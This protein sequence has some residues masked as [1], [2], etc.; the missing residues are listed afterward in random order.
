MFA[1]NQLNERIRDMSEAVRDIREQTG[2]IPAIQEHLGTLNGSVARHEQLIEANRAA[3][4]AAVRE[5]HSAILAGDEESARMI[6]V[7]AGAVDGFELK[8]KLSQERQRGRQDVYGMLIRAWGWV[9]RDGVVLKLG[10]ALTTFLLGLN[11]LR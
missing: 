2:H 6:R 4:A 1:F 3:N 10:L 8:D 5:L 7:V 9:S 11:L